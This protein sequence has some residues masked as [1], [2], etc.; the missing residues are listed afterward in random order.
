MALTKFLDSAGRE[1]YKD[2]QNNVYTEG[3]KNPTYMDVNQWNQRQLNRYGGG[4]P[5]TYNPNF[6]A[7]TN[8]GTN[9]GNVRNL[10]SQT[11]NPANALRDAMAKAESA[12]NEQ[13]NVLKQ[14]EQ[15]MKDR[16]TNL[17]NTLKGQQTVAEGRQSVAT[18]NELGRRGISMDSGVAQQ[19]LTD[20]LNPITQSYT[21]LI[22]DTGIQR[23]MDL[24]SLAEQIA[25]LTGQRS[26]VMGGLASQIGQSEENRLNS[27][28]NLAAQLTQM[29]EDKRRFGIGQQLSPFEKWRQD[30]ISKI[31]NRGNNQSEPLYSPG[32]GEGTK[33]N[34]YVF[35]NGRWLKDP[36]VIGSLFDL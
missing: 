3:G 25:A 8:F 16:Y 21:G 22:K 30:L 2:T 14:R 29:E 10:Y 19:Q 4:N 26:Q 31:V 15:P 12:F 7:S 5:Q 27:M 17:I 24:L 9:Y 20:Q 23:E 32:S 33:A 11:A 34:G 13:S 1:A 28:L 18:T 35:T 6:Q 36:D